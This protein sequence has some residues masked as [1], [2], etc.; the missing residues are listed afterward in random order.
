MAGI[1][2]HTKHYI[3]PIWLRF[4]ALAA[5]IIACVVFLGPK[6]LFSS[7][8]T[9]LPWNERERMLSQGRERQFQISEEQPQ[10]T[11]VLRYKARVELDEQPRG[12]IN[13]LIYPDGMV[14]GIWN[15][16]YDRTED[17]H[18]LIMA[19]SFMGNIEPSKKYVEDGVADK[20]KLYF[21]TG[22]GYN[23]FETE[24]ATKQQRN[25]NGFVYV[26]GWIDPNYT[27]EGELI[28]TKDKKNFETFSWAA[29]PVN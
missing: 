2:V 5:G 18:C 21:L 11:Y 28:I 16:E 10:L 12:E 27:A 24:P 8:D 14:K 1:N 26:R 20:S 19:S 22:G 17:I 13:I 6:Y 9:S 7:Y 23:T 3:Y 4:F 15:G 29:H 25:I